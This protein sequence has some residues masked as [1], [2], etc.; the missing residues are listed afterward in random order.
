MKSSLCCYLLSFLFLVL[1]Y[2]S[3]SQKAKIEIETINNDDNSVDL[4]YEKNLPGSYD[5]KL[6]F[7]NITNCYT[8][9]FNTVVKKN[10]GKLLRLI[11][12]DPKVGI[13]FSLNY[14]YSLGIPNPKIDPDFIYHLP[15]KKGKKISV[16]LAQDISVKYFGKEKKSDWFSY[17][18]N[19]ESADTICSI[20]KGIVIDIIN[21]FD[22]NT[23][24]N[25][26]Y[27]NKRNS[28]VV[29]HP[30]G[31]FAEYTGFKRNGIFVNIG[32]Q[33]YPQTELGIIDLLNDAYRFDFS[34][35][36]KSVAST[37]SKNAST[38]TI[39]KFLSPYFWSEEGKI[40]INSS[41]SCIVD[42]N[43]ELIILEFTKSEKKKFFNDK[44]SFINQK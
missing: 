31:T 20:R 13:R 37:K 2:K 30:D 19:S 33:I 4:L 9:E 42:S 29:E 11:P 32:Q 35:Y 26:Q 44:N 16:D 25:L 27:T 23:S 22:T 24:N 43:D 17:V 36:Y 18:V 15:F 3:Y 1:N 38:E 10:S 39:Y 28:I 7:T 40:K 5:I 8:Y 12:N 34:I 14:I 41:T 6:N 21:D